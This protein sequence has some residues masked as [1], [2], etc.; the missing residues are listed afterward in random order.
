MRK[1]N[2]D[3]LITLGVGILLFTT[4]FI[5]KRRTGTYDWLYVILGAIIIIIGFLRISGFMRI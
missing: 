4:G 2:T 1:M 3:N 5:F